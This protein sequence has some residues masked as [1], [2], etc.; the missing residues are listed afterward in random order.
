MSNSMYPSQY[1]RALS[2]VISKG[3]FFGSKDYS[4]LEIPLEIYQKDSYWIIK[5][6]VPGVAKEDVHVD[7][8]GGKIT[9]SGVRH[10]PEEKPYMTEIEYGEMRTTV[11]VA[12]LTH[13]KKENVEANLKEGVLFIQVKRDAES[14][15]YQVTIS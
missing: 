5:A 8:E 4:G 7:V 13:I 12:A 1:A 9:I 3:M 10:K 2:D 11:K 14:V 15:P 6:Y